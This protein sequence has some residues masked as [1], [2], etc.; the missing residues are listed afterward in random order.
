MDAR[1]AGKTRFVGYS[2]EN[3][4]AEWAVKN[5]MFD[6]LQSA[7]NLMDQKARYGLFDLCRSK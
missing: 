5:G 1:D 4:D 2:G 3:E 6:T 7:F